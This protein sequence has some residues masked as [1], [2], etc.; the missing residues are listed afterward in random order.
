MSRYAIVHDSVVVN[1]AKA[2]APLELNWVAS[3]VAQI[4]W[5]YA[6]GEFSPPP[7]PTVPVPAVV[8][9]RQARLALLQAGLL[10]SVE[11]AMAGASAADQIEWEYATEVR[12]DSPLVVSMT[13]ALGWTAEQVDDLFRTAA[14]L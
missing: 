9:M 2:G 5:L 13:A 8:S 11:T 12:R 10:A 1:I 6:D 3:D 7:E 14:S 4:G